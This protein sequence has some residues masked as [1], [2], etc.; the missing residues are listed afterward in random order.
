MAKPFVTPPGDGSLNVS[1]V[2]DFHITNCNLTPAFSFATEDG[3][4]AGTLTNISH[5]EYARAAHRVAH[6]LRPQPNLHD[7]MDGQVVAI[8]ALTDTLPYQ[9]LFAGC[10]A[11]GLVPFSISH[12]NSDAALKHLLTTGKA[13][14][15]LTTRGSL[16]QVMDSLAADLLAQQPAYAISIQEIPTL[17]EMYPLLGRETPEDP[18]TQYSRPGKEASLTET[19]LYLHS[20]G[21]TGL[22]KPIPVS[23]RSAI[24]IAV[25]EVFT[26]TREISPRMSVGAL[27]AFHAM[28]F[29]NHFLSP[30]FNGVV[31]CIYPPAVEEEYRVPVAVTPD[32]A[33]EQTKRAQAT[34][35]L[36][37]P[38]FLM[39]WAQ[40]EEDVKYLSSL[41]FVS[42]SGGPLPQRVGDFLVSQGVKLLSIYGGTEFGGV[43]VYP[44]QL[45]A[46]DWSW[47][48]FS[49]RMDVRWVPAG[50]NTFE[51]QVLTCKTHYPAIEDLPDVKGYATKDLFE[52]HPDPAK[53]HLYRIVGRVDDVLIMANGEKTVPNAIEDI[54]SS[55]PHVA[56]AM[57][58]GRGRNQVGVLVE[59]A[60]AS[61]FSLDLDPR[62]DKHLSDFRNLIW[63]VVEQANAI[64][65]AFAKVY[66]EMILVTEGGRPMV[67]APKGT[68]V[69]KATI[70]LYEG[71]IEALYDTIE[72]SGN[73]ANDVAPPTS[74]TATELEP[75]LLTHTGL[76]FGKHSELKPDIDLFDQGFDSL[77]ATFLRHRIVAALRKDAKGVIAQK[78][79]QN[80]V[81]AYP[82]IRQL[83][84]AIEG[85]VA[86]KVSGDADPRALVEAMIAKYS[87]G[88]DVLPASEQRPSSRA[89]ILLTG[90]TGGLGS[91]ILD[92]LLRHSSVE[93]VYA[94]NRPSP[95]PISQRQEAAFRDRALDVGLL[96]SSKLVYLQGDSTREDL[97]LS[98]QV[99]AELKKTVTVVIHTAWVLDFNK[100]LSTFEPHVRGTRNFIDLARS[101]SARARFLF[102]S[103][104][105]SAQGWDQ[106]KGPVPEELQL[107]AGVA[108]GNGY[109]EAKYVSERILAASNLPATSF[110]IG[111]VSGAQ[112]NGA[113]STTDWV[114]AIVKS[115][116]A[117]GNFPSDPTGTGT[118]AWLPTEAVSQAIVDIALTEDE[119]PFAVNL[120]HPRPVVWDAVMGA[121]AQVAQLPLI[122]ITEWVGQV[123]RRANNASVEDM[124]KFPA[125]K[126]LDFLK[127]AIGGSGNV[128]FST[129]QAQRV[130]Q[131][132]A[133]LRPLSADDATRWM[134]YWSSVGFI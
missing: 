68:V 96:D 115:S 33:L 47:V 76:I 45:R 81:Y 39:Q 36:I 132:M 112:S 38:I 31:A 83:A 131:T 124:E 102:T 94:F 19:A 41:D 90:S 35:I 126:L 99:L 120:V 123:E 85:L 18:F 58:F 23:H 98:E 91:H 80:L 65:P 32:N 21:S 54:I 55:S 34:G 119:Q 122:P 67:R 104:I 116:I 114:P 1:Q 10:I 27:P 74:W 93:R 82:S 11:A 60:S 12:R 8:I 127:T 89:V 103:S 22:P 17:A 29:F 25:L 128:Q 43:N 9:T 95:T 109:G 107:D 6:L 53:S 111:Q 46:S 88:L 121:M 84:N 42:Y 71:D 100:S 28:G 130:S 4:G 5:F 40:K 3:D 51:C 2:I 110:R 63:S 92:I 37:V 108:V 26:Q 16:G 61:A 87:E 30:V 24:S 129:T 44:K 105:A 59:P 49:D 56:N 77:N 70:K 14:R 69:K 66:K 113:W 78:I 86:G 106:S 117:L 133:D 134:G 97:G 101:S 62:D 52:R 48:Q 73:A 7:G 50:D 125:I 15:I 20:S 118:V 75:W 13:Q 57:I 64:A 79:P 72:A